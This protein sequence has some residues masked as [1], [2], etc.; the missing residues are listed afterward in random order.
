VRWNLDD[1]LPRDKFDELEREIEEALKKIDEYVAE[2]SNGMSLEKFREITE[3]CETLS[4]K[5]SRLITLPELIEST[6]Q[7]DRKAK[8]LKSRANNISLKYTDRVRKIYHWVK[9]FNGGLDEVNAQRLFAGVP[10]LKYVLDYSRKAAKHSLSEKEESIVDNKDVSGV[11]ALADLRTII[12]TEF[13]YSL[14]VLKSKSLKVE[15]PCLPTPAGKPAGR[16]DSLLPEADQPM[17]EKVI[18]TQAELTALFHSPKA[19][20]REAAYRALLEKH[21]ENLDKFFLIYQA[22]A[23]DWDY[24]AKIRGY[25]SPLSM[26]N[27]G[28]QVSDKSVEVLLRVVA[29]NKGVFKN[30]FEY[31]AKKLGVKKLSRFDLYAPISKK[32]E[33]H[34][35]RQAGLKVLKSK[36]LKVISFEEAEKMVL[37]AF[38]EFSPRFADFGRKI[39]EE[40]HIDSHPRVGKRSGAFCANVGP[41]VTPYVM[42]NHTGRFR[43][44]TTLAHELGHGIHSLYANSHYPSSQHAGLTLA[45]TASTFGEMILFEKMFKE[46]K[47]KQEKEEMLVEKIADSYATIMRQSYFI[48]FEIKAH[49]TV[50]EG[51]SADELSKLWL[52]TLEDQFGESVFV[53]KVFGSEW[54]Y[55]PHIV[56]TPFYC[57]AYS[58]GEL[59]SY[60]LFSR[61]KKEGK[62]FVPKIEKI[63]TAG[64]SEDPGLI[65]KNVGIDIESEQFWQEGFEL[66]KEWSSRLSDNDF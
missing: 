11:E 8:I 35:C 2:L 5:L 31:K 57:Y 52:S 56:E 16:S 37:G 38:E 7:K 20:L 64:G 15:K 53:D 12:E 34:A 19:E 40:N 22:V 27:F 46:T 3:Y 28:N 26:R 54:S 23:K 66:I 42:L 30:Y 32:S 25:A 49:E 39:I 62:S 50:Q 59:L 47:G 18:E 58:F 45:E 63:L 14:K 10:D 55:I 65:L 4:Q 29:K 1:I 61:Y 44:V 24:E 17:V 9:G 13:K 6:D 60:S 51:I 21:E 48:D 33:S 43:D 36:S 41:A